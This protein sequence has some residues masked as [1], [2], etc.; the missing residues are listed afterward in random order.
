MIFNV[1][2]NNNNN[3]EQNF[4]KIDKC[5]FEINSVIT[6]ICKEQV[7]KTIDDRRV[8]IITEGDIKCVYNTAIISVI[9]KFITISN[10]CEKIYLKECAS[11]GIEAGK[12][13]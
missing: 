12:L 3:H 13:R 8:D 1:N 2:N 6:K 7:L 9:H 4:V 11:A 5:I 10:E